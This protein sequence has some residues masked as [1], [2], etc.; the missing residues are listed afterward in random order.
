MIPVSHVRRLNHVPNLY[1]TRRNCHILQRTAPSLSHEH[2][3]RH[4]QMISQHEDYTSSRVKRLVTPVSRCGEK[5]Q[6]CTK[7]PSHEDKLPHFANDLLTW[8][9]YFI[10]HTGDRWL[11]YLTPLRFNHVSTLYRTSI[12]CHT[13]QM[14]SQHEDHTSPRTKRLMTPVS[15]CSEK[16]S[17]CTKPLAA[18]G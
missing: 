6:S 11:L 10:S 7:P 4:L 3:L 13:L 1:R 12:N 14:I 16:T 2:K 15:R 5:A 8:G 18:R 9:S 17:S